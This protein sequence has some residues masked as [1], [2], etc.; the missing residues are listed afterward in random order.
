MEALTGINYFT[1]SLIHFLS[2]GFTVQLGNLGYFKITI[3]SKGSPT[4][5]D[6]IAG[7]LTAIKLH[8]YVSEAMRKMV[9]SFRIARFK[10]RTHKVKKLAGSAL[11]DSAVVP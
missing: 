11:S 2:M 5:E 6:V 7:K 1:K 8:F 4:L 9:Q 3:K 10:K